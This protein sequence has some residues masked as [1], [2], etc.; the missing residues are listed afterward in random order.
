MPRIIAFL[1]Y[2]DEAASSRQ[3]FLQ[4]DRA[5]KEAG[6]EVEYQSLLDNGHM[7]RLADGRTVGKMSAAVAY[8]RRLGA[9]FRARSFD[10]AWVQYE[11]FPF[12]P[13]FTE[14]LATVLARQPIVVDYDDAIFH[15]YDENGSRGFR[16]IL[17]GKLEPLLRRA[18]AC[19]C[20]NLYL[21][22]YAA[23]FCRTEI[24][25]TV[26]DTSIY[27]PERDRQNR[28]GHVVVGWIGSPS[29]WPN[30]RP[31]LPLLAKLAVSHGIKVRAIGAGKAAEADCFPGLQLV[32]WNEY[33]EISELQRLDIGIMPL[34]DRPFE[35]GKCGY[36][37]IQY[38]GC[39]LPVVASPVGVNSEIVTSGVTGLLATTEQEWHSA[40]LRLIQDP[41]LRR[42][43]GGAGRVR[44]ELDFSLDRQAPRLIN[45]M[46]D[47]I[48]T[49]R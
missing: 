10:L 40:L 9:V 44:A 41:S 3:R 28:D 7:R 26:I 11:F 23:H 6:Y 32:E 22:D 29:T 33:T 1:K 24:I 39:G 13:G 42:A 35:R 21:R 37:L 16:H 46:R 27:L 18:A 8:G 20:G 36:K 4:Y 38:M 14:T 45:L 49:R 25:P 34:L 15:R 43:F 5:L 47:V 48:R 17:D 2:G 31:L 12:L 19:V 30:V